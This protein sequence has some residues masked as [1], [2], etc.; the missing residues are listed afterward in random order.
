MLNVLGLIERGWYVFPL[1]PDS[2]IP[3]K[4]F[5]WKELSSN[6][7]PQIEKWLGEYPN[8]N[9]AID[10]GKSGL[11][12]IDEDNKGGKDGAGTLFDLDLAGMVLP[13][14]LV[15]IT[16][17]GGR[18]HIYRGVVKSTAGKIGEGVDTRGAGGYIVGP[19]STINGGAYRIER[20]VPVDGVP[21]WVI[22]KAGV[23]L[24]REARE[25]LPAVELDQPG[26]LLKAIDYLK[27]ATPSVEGDGGDENAFRVICR[28]RDF[29][30]SEMMALDLM[31]RDEWNERCDPPWGVDELQ[32]K[33]ANAYRYAHNQ[34]GAATAEAAFAGQPVTG[35]ADPFANVEWPT[36]LADFEA[37]PPPRKWVVDQWVPLDSTV[38]FTGAGGTGKSLV[39]LQMAISCGF[40]VPWCGEPI[41]ED[42][43]PL[44]IACE[45]SK[46]ELTRRRAEVFTLPEYM[47][48]DWQGNRDRV[49]F[50]AR[51]GCDNYLALLDRNGNLT[52]GPFY[53]VVD[54]WLRRQGGGKKLLF[55]DT[56]S[57]CFAG[58]ENDN[59]QVSYYI[60]HLLAG[61][62]VKHNAT[63][64]IIHHT[65]KSSDSQYRGATAWVNACRGAILMRPHDDDQMATAGYMMLERFKANYAKR[66]ET[67][68][69][70]WDHG[71][72]HRV[73]NEGE[74]FD[75]LEKANLDILQGKIIEAV[76]SGVAINQHGGSARPLSQEPIKDINGDVMSAELKKRLVTQLIAE[77]SVEKKTKGSR[78]NGLYPT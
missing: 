46:A 5:H 21:A 60:K 1:S 73:N 15:A 68:T 30:I 10:C 54:E 32:T 77:G 28:V 75:D 76:D 43:T 65:A 8:C 72:F 16:P 57:D 20:D 27:K 12:V 14:T 66:G 44:Y 11:A 61:L 39:G 9:W 52:P 24:D 64:I 13:P 78:G 22:D 29:G 36:D 56:A 38:L 31:L 69:V 18:H 19:G 53:H 34:A 62:R 70:K 6:D 40:N 63:I 33:V 59:V 37:K 58:S 45:D 71:A 42:V 26:H 48:L 47:A 3:F 55:I 35:S 41:G 49:K 7:R 4:D 50:W 74:I 51:E 17:T 2:K 23:P 25:E 67:F